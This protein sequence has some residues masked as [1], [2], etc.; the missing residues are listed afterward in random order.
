MSKISIKVDR[1]GAKIKVYLREVVNYPIHSWIEVYTDEDLANKAYEATSAADEI[2]VNN[3]GVAYTSDFEMYLIN[4]HCDNL[5]DYNNSPEQ[6]R[7][8]CGR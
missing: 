1:T 6:I 8:K 2:Y 5:D 7:A 3:A 4:H